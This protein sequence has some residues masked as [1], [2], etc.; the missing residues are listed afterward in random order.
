MSARFQKHQTVR[1]IE[2][3]SSELQITLLTRVVARAFEIGHSAVKRAQFRGYDDPPTR[4]RH[5][6]LTADAEQQFVD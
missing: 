4:G 2:F 6:E 1:L 5:H 3:A